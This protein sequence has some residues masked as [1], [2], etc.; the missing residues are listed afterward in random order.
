MSLRILEF[1][2]IPSILFFPTQ[3]C[4][5][6]ADKGFAPSPLTDVFA[7]NVSFLTALFREHVKKLAFLADSSA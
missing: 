2:N 1:K 5:V 3:T 4:I 7:K 6:G